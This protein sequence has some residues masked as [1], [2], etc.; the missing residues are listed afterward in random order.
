MEFINRDNVA[1]S[2]N[3]IATT[4]HWDL[5]I[6]SWPKAVYYPGDALFKVRLSTC[7]PPLLDLSNELISEKIHGFEILQHGETLYQGDLT[8]TIRDFVDQSA[9]NIFYDAFSKI[10]DPKTRL[11]LPK[12]VLYWDMTLYQLDRRLNPIKEYVMKTGLLKNFN[13]S[14]SFTGDIGNQPPFSF[15]IG[16]EFV[17]VNLLNT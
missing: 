15:G 16:F 2:H 9:A 4:F 8:G 11:G 10:I 14:E 12:S 17:T 1:G 3:E 6:D 7:V 5:Q 13:T